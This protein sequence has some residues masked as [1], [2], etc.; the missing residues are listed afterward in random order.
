MRSI[1]CM[2]ILAALLGSCG[3][4]TTTSSADS[5]QTAIEAINKAEADFN[6]MAAHY[7]WGVCHHSMLCWSR[8]T[9]GIYAPER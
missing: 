2:F 4:A 1:T 5:K 6:K 3:E 8:K 9:T 7:E